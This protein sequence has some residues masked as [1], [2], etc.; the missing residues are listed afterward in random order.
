M[1]D[2]HEKSKKCKKKIDDLTIAKKRI[3]APF[4]EILN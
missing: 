1:K 4:V 2:I 3:A